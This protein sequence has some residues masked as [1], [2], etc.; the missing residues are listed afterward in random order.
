MQIAYEINTK[1]TLLV[2][3]LPKNSKKQ[4]GRHDRRVGESNQVRI[5]ALIRRFPIRSLT[6]QLVLK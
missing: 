3:R 6:L 4:K 2:H 1:L 5:N